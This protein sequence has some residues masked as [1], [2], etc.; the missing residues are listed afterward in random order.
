MRGRR[1]PEIRIAVPE[2]YCTIYKA[3]SGIKWTEIFVPPE[4]INDYDNTLWSS[5]MVEPAQV[6]NTGKNCIYNIV[7][8]NDGADIVNS[9][10]DINRRIIAT[11]V[12]QP[13]QIIGRYLKYLRFIRFSKDSDISPEN[14]NI[15]SMRLY[16]DM[17]AVGQDI[18][19]Y[20]NRL[21]KY[22]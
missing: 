15:D 1:D 9:T 13:H 7:R 21:P 10:K 3:N 8:V 18:L 11:E 5:I 4:D 12:L 19:Y 6:D 16:Q 20:I 2:K 22:I 14:L 17:T